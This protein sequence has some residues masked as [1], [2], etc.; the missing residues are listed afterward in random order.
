MNQPAA[1]PD[2]ALALLAGCP[3]LAGIAPADVAAGLG[4]ADCRWRRIEPGERLYR[5]GE[6]FDHVFGLQ[7][8]SCKL[9]AG[10]REGREAITTVFPAGAW[11]GDLQCFSGLPSMVDCVA[12]EPGRVLMLRGSALLALADRWPRIHRQLLADVC[13]KSRHSFF[14][15]IQYKLASPE[16]KLAR[17][18]EVAL[19]L[20]PPEPTPDGW[21]TLRER[22]SHEQLAQMLGLSRPR[23]T[24]AVQALAEAGLLRGGRGRFEVNV[25]ALRDYG[26]REGR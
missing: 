2:D 13:R 25:A 9:V 11:F 17:R 12:A 22:L 19:D 7:A 26:L 18:L 8:G 23:V 5:T 15:A 21:V 3:W 24:L 20:N 4:P 1:L 6:R 16:L 14:M 10:S